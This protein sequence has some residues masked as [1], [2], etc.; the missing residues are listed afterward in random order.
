MKAGSE[1]AEFLGIGWGY[2]IEWDKNRE[3]FA[4]A[5]YEESIRQSIWIILSTAPGERVM[6]QQRRHSGYGR[7]SRA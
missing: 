6:R 4:T 2:P 1:M 5:E 7:A 3:G